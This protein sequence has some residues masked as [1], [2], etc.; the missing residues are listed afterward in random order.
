MSQQAPN[1]NCPQCDGRLEAAEYAQ[2]YTCARCGRTIRESVVS[3]MERFERVAEGDGPLAE[4]A[5][6]ALE[7]EK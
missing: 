6:A 4:I 5:A 7:G 2:E 1:Y 3:R